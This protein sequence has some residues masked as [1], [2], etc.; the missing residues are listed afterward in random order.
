MQFD[1]L[2]VRQPAVLKKK[3]WGLEAGERRRHFVDR[4]P[5]WLA[6]MQGI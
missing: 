3:E 2:L 6:A 4:V 1:R 5:L